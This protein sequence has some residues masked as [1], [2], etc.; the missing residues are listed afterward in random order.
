MTDR[1]YFRSKSD[2]LKTL[3]DANQNNADVLTAIAGEL[4]HR[5]SRAAKRLSELVET[6]LAAIVPGGVAPATTAT[7]ADEG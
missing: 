3:I 6:H 7:V 1:P 4:S 5:K 2:E